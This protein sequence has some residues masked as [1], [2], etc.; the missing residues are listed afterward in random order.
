MCTARGLRNGHYRGELERVVL[1]IVI[2]DVRVALCIQCEGRIQPANVLFHRLYLPFSV[3]LPG[4]IIERLSS[5]VA[6]CNV[7]NIVAIELERNMV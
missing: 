6:E 5:W 7:G 3:R 1:S 2:T 4:S